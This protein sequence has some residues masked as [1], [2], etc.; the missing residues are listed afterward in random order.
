MASYLLWFILYHILVVFTWKKMLLIFVSFCRCWPKDENVM[1]VS[2]LNLNFTI[3][4][5]TSHTE[6]NKVIS[7]LQKEPSLP[8]FETVTSSKSSSSS[9]SSLLASQKS[10]TILHIV[11][12]HKQLNCNI[13]YLKQKLSLYKELTQALPKI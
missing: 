9:S 8:N 4:K 12:L 1:I 11:K 13:K 2:W 6:Q 5:S 7:E 10:S 3:Q